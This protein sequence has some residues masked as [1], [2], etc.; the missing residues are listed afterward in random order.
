MDP[1][2]GS[3]WKSKHYL[4][5]IGETMSLVVKSMRMP[6]VTSGGFAPQTT[7][8]GQIKLGAHHDLLAKGNQGSKFG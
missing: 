1:M 7:R 4:A 5:P 2:V 6:E 8:V 3:T